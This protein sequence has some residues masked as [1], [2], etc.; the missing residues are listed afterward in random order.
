[1]SDG[2]DRPV[3]LF[4]EMGMTTVRL[5]RQHVHLL[6]TEDKNTGARSRRLV[7]CHEK[8]LKPSKEAVPA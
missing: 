2:Y 3:C 1:M 4:C 8:N 6:K 5:R 7:V